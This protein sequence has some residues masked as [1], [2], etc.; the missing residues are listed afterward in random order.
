[1][2]LNLQ[3]HVPAVSPEIKRPISIGKE[4]YKYMLFSL[5]IFKQENYNIIQ[6]EIAYPSEC[7]LYVS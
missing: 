5:R 7:V 2:A 4:E 1:M 3:R 6:M